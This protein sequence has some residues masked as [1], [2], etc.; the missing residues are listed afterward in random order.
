MREVRGVQARLDPSAYTIRYTKRGGIG[1]PYLT[2]E[3]G[4]L[5]TFCAMPLVYRV[6]ARF[7]VRN[8]GFARVV[9]GV[10]EQVCV[11]I[12][13]ILLSR[14]GCCNMVGELWCTTPVV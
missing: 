6:L 11:R 8:S 12:E 9:R 3:E 13:P 10:C 7:Q 4:I 1:S 14:I 2:K 5:S